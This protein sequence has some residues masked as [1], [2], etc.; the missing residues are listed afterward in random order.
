VI[1]A[2]IF[3]DVPRANIN[4]SVIAS[5]EHMAARIRGAAERAGD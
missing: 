3:P 5:A 4:I 2:S 1:D